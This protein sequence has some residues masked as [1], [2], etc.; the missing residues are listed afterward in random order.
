[1]SK[2]PPSLRKQLATD[3]FYQQ[4]ARR[5]YHG[6][7]C[8]GRITWEHAMTY[9]GKQI[10]ERWA[11]IPLCAKAHNVDDWQDRGDMNKDINKWIALNRATPNEI[12]AIS[13][14]EDY[15]MKKHWLNVRFGVWGG[16]NS[17]EKLLVTGGKAVD[18]LGINYGTR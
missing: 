14:G 6:H 11:I 2:I 8:A 5:G 10:Q 1:M 4:C 15:F 16:E 9:A 7:E 17:V 3:P 18:G 13:R 12:L